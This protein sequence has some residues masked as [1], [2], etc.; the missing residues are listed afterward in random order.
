MT[1][2]QEMETVHPD[3]LNRLLENRRGLGF[4]KGEFKLVFAVNTRQSR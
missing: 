3:K 2:A 1:R 4:T